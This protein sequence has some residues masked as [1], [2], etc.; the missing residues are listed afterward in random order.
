MIYV[1]LV[2][3]KMEWCRKRKQNGKLGLESKWTI[4]SVWFHWFGETGE[5]NREVNHGLFIIKDHMK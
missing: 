4:D 2:A 3:G 5:E 1:C